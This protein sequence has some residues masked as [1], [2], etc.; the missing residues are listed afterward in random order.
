[1]S[2]VRPSRVTLVMEAGHVAPTMGWLNSYPNDSCCRE[3]GHTTSTIGWSNESPND[4]C[5]RGAGHV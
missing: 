3:A 5:W 1:H 4:S 2:R